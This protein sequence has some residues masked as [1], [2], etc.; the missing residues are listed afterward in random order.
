MTDLRSSEQLLFP[1]FEVVL[2]NGEMIFL[3]YDAATSNFYFYS[4]DG[5]QWN[6]TDVY[7]HNDDTTNYYITK[8]IK[9]DYS[10]KAHL[11]THNVQRVGFYGRTLTVK[12]S[13][14]ER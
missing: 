13:K 3:L 14:K 7:I 1:T 12:A 11:K 2:A 5:H 6:E 4:F 10:S 8:I 9:K